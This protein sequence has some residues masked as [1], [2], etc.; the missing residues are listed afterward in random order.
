LGTTIQEQQ[1]IK[2]TFFASG[3]VTQ[4]GLISNLL[5]GGN[6]RIKLPQFQGI[7]LG[8]PNYSNDNPAATSTPD[9]IG[10]QYQFANSASRNKSWS[11][12]DLA[13]ELTDADPVG[14]ITAQVAQYWATDD[15]RRLIQSAL[16]ILADN[17]ANDS[18]DMVV[19]ISDDVAGTVTAAERI[20]A[21][22]VIDAE[23][24]LGD[25]KMNLSAIAM[26]SVL[27]SRLRK[28]GALLDIHNPE[29]GAL[30]Y[31][32]FNGKR[33]VVDD[34]L[35]AVAGTNRI[36]YTCVLFGA[37]AIGYGTGPVLNPAEMERDPAA[38]NGGG[39]ET[40]FS[41]V[42]TCFHPYGFEFKDAAIAGQSPT[43]AELANAS[44]WSRVVARKNVPMAFLQV[45]D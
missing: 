23:Q 41:R 30:T 40:I 43:Y 42:N 3:I 15:E 4:D 27:H 24:T 31:T 18:G 26:H 33:V 35:P 34:S 5:A 14:A 11:S 29:T 2:N 17:V 45:N 16:G 36:K 21:G 28:E 38:G 20:S 19:D 13:R 1:T 9:K 7:A 44:S 39:Q 10:T 12:M 22:A 6:D 32:T 37:G 8:E 25:H